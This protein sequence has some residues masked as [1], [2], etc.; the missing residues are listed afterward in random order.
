MG[1]E[2]DVTTQEVDRGIPWSEI[3]IDFIY[4]KRLIDSGEP[5]YYALSDLASKYNVNIS[6]LS[7]RAYKEGW[8]DKRLEAEEEMEKEVAKRRK[9]LVGTKIVSS[10]IKIIAVTDAIVNECSRKMM[11]ISRKN[12]EDINAVELKNI[13]TTVKTA[14]DTLIMS[15]SILGK[16]QEET[17]FDKFISM[18]T[19][20]L[21]QVDTTLNAIAHDAHINLNDMEDSNE[22]EELDGV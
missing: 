9:K 2:L 13:S 17:A 11:A 16:T 8:L 7:N 20:K 5:R 3:R 22:D 14:Q 19:D 4:G 12:A 15:D 21:S 1:A 18:Y 6:T 10:H